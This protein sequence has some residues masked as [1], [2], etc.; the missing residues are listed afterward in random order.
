MGQHRPRRHEYQLGWWLVTCGDGDQVVPDWRGQAYEIE[1]DMWLYLCP[2]CAESRDDVGEGEGRDLREYECPRCEE[3]TD[4]EI[5]GKHEWGDSLRR[6][7]AC[8]NCGLVYTRPS[9]NTAWVGE[10]YRLCT[11]DAGA[12]DNQVYVERHHNLVEGESDYCDVITS[13]AAAGNI[14]DQLR[15]DGYEYEEERGTSGSA[16]R[17]RIRVYRSDDGQPDNLLDHD[18]EGRSGEE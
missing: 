6:V 16:V 13:R 2:S 8:N 15:A 11:R 12:P 18:D 3:H 7:V 5:V 10:V 1:R 17:V 4:P 9:R 14:T